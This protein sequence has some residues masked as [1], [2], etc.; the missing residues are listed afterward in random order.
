VIGLFPWIARQAFQHDN[1]NHSDYRE[2]VSNFFFLALAF[3]HPGSLS[4]RLFVLRK[5]NHHNVVALQ[6]TTGAAAPTHIRVKC[7]SCPAI[8]GYL[9]SPC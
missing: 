4:G 2:L 6:A 8:V 3:S 1:P 5:N 7:C 9:E